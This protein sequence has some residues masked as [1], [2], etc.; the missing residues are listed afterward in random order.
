MSNAVALTKPVKAGTRH[1]SPTVIIFC[2]IGAILLLTAILA[3]WITPH[4]PNV[5]VLYD[6][7][8][9]PFWQKGGSMQFPLGT[10]T[11]GRDVLSRLIY[12][13][14][15]TLSVCALV[16]AIA[17]SL[18]TFLGIIAGYLGKWFDTIIM[19]A[20]DLVFSL[21]AVLLALLLGAIFGPSF[22]ILV[23]II[24]FTLWAGYARMARAETLKVKGFDFISLAKIAGCSQ[25][26]IMMRHIFPNIV[27]P[28]IILA[29]LQVGTIV[30]VE[31]SLS[32]L[33]VGIPPPTADWGSMISDGRSYIVTAW[34]LCIIPG[35]AIALT[36]LT[37]NLLGDALND[38]L[39]PLIHRR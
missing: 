10:D 12:G 34:W 3:P 30:I 14:R 38:W 22:E 16:V 7:L 21:P 19:R 35:V 13:A 29:T 20:V 11:L 6:R 17:G 9:P 28:I 31:A 25:S 5:G 26:S 27:S 1:M 24:S 23:L 18:G 15:T 33:G 32:F 37:F 39:N 2:I 36:V 8:K 4:N